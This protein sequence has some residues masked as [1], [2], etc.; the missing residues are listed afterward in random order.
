M[1]NASFFCYH[2]SEGIGICEEENGCVV[3]Y[4]S[5]GMISLCSIYTPAFTI[6]L[7]SDR[8]RGT[9]LLAIYSLPLGTVFLMVCTLF[10]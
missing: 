6:S 2:G 5:A 1:G 8:H 10:T 9:E 3:I 7:E 4:G